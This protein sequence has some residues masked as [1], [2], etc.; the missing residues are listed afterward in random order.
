VEHARRTLR[1]IQQNLWFAVGIKVA[2]LVAA[3]L[4]EATLWMAVLADTGATLAV[5]MN[6]LRLLRMQ[7]PPVSHHHHHHDGEGG[8]TYQAAQSH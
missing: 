4:G 2:F 5:T 1:V 7:A 6:G 8:H 3:A